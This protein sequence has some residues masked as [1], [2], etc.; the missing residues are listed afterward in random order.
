C[1]LSFSDSSPVH[2]LI[3][4]TVVL[5]VAN[6]VGAN[7]ATVFTWKIE[8]SL[9]PSTSMSMSTT[10]LDFIASGSMLNPLARARIC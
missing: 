2:A 10:D 8:T 5:A 1:R 6:L 9:S 7:M 3:E 4:V